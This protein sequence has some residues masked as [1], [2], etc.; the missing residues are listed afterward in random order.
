MAFPE[1]YRVVKN[2]KALPYSYPQTCIVAKAHVNVS[3]FNGGGGADT[4]PGGP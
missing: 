3:T 4:N 1:L 2:L